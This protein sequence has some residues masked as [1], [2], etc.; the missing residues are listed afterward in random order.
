M[1]TGASRLTEV[2]LL[3]VADPACRSGTRGGTQAA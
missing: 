3:A 2:W 1:Q